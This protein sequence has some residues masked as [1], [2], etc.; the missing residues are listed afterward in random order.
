MTKGFITIATGKEEYYQLARNL[1][2]SYRYFCAEPLPF[3]ILADRENEY[4]AEFDNVL[5]FSWRF[6]SFYVAM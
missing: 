2:H 6:S 3:A 4:T 1:L 5:L